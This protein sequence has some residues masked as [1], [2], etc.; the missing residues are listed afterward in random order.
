M[1][2]ARELEYPLNAI[3]A[4]SISR[5]GTTPT[6]VPRPPFKL[7]GSNFQGR[8]GEA[9]GRSRHRYSCLEHQERVLPEPIIQRGIDTP[10]QAQTQELSLNG[11]TLIRPTSGTCEAFMTKLAG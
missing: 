11:G 5:G 4:Q 9:D 2:V 7:S 6:V 1:L 3:L 8:K 10:L